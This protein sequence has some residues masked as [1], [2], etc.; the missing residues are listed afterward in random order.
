MYARRLL[1]VVIALAGC[2]SDQKVPSD[3]HARDSIPTVA[4]RSAANP[5]RDFLRAMSDYD[6]GLI[7]IVSGAL[8]RK[9]KLSV[10]DDAQRLSEAHERELDEVSTMLEKSYSDW[11]PPSVV[12]RHQAMADS[13]K[14]LKGRAYDRTFLDNVIRHHEEGSKM[15]DAFLPRLK[16]PSV[17]SLAD[18][19]HAVQ[20]RELLELKKQVRC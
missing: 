5:D 3:N 12:P 10:R 9:E 8:D 4:V 11:Y 6:W 17:R 1:A 18:K 19:M 16:N 2:S 13:L 15:I 20:T 7:G 14:T